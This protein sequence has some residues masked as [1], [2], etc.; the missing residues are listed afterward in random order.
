MCNKSNGKK[1][2][3]LHHPLPPITSKSLLNCINNK[4]RFYTSI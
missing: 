2:K 3:Q 4:L 1:A